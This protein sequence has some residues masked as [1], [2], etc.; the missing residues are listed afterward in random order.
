[1]NNPCPYT[2]LTS[3]VPHFRPRH[4]R[5]WKFLVG[6]SERQAEA[7]YYD[8]LMDGSGEGLAASFH[9]GDDERLCGD[10]GAR[11]GLD[12]ATATRELI[13]LYGLRAAAILM[14]VAWHYLGRPSGPNS[15][16]WK[17]THFGSSGVDLA[18]AAAGVADRSFGAAGIV[19]SGHFAAAEGGAMAGAAVSGLHRPIRRHGQGAE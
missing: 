4:L 6:A 12:V 17:A 8:G 3:N 14:V 2:S 10:F 11:F 16:L 19:G 7:A 5:W 15:L 18:C 1:M 9:A 13:E